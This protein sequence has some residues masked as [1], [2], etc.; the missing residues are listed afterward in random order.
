MQNTIKA[1]A[2]YKTEEAQVIV[3]HSEHQF[4]K[5]QSNFLKRNLW[6]RLSIPSTN[7]IS[8][9]AT[10]AKPRVFTDLKTNY[11]YSFELLSN[12]PSRHKTNSSRF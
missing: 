8:V 7:C 11:L 5:D 12:F 10:V 1:L 9:L 3:R 2:P 6:R 4:Q